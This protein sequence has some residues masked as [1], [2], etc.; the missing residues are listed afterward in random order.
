M[1]DNKDLG[2]EIL[3]HLKLYKDLGVRWVRPGSAAVSAANP[4]AARRES[5]KQQPAIRSEKASL[6][7]APIRPA[8]PTSGAPILTRQCKMR[9][10]YLAFLHLCLR[11]WAWRAKA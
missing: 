9:K 7:T 2:E 5:Q 11:T 6:P 1:T 10:N 3:E 8:S 4:V